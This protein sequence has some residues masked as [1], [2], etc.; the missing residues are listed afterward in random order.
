VSITNPQT[1]LGPRLPCKATQSTK[2]LG[3]WEESYELA[4]KS[5]EEC[6]LQKQHWTNVES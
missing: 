4:C 6:Q 1:E 5:L 2:V 3:R